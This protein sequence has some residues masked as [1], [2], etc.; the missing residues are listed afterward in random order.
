MKILVLNGS[1][2]LNGNTAALVESFKNGAE[3][4]E[5]EV[6]VLQV[7]RMKIGGCLNCDGCKNS[8]DGKCVVKDDMQ[9]VYDEMEK[10]DLLVIASPIHYWSFTGQMQCAISRFYAPFKPSVRKYAMI[11][12][13]GDDGVYNA[14]VSQYKDMLEWFEAED[15]GIKTVFGEHNKSKEAL[16]E[17]YEFGKSVK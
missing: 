10:C 7:G 14:P 9:T 3:S 4:S 13:S 12:S 15:L 2:R 16:D 11:L 5:N 1:P 6:K 8:T 17:M